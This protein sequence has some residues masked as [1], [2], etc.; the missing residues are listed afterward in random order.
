MPIRDF[1][2]LV[3]D[4][5]EKT[6]LNRVRECLV[7]LQDF[8]RLLDPR[9]PPGAE[10]VDRYIPQMLDRCRRCKGKVLV[11]EIDGRVAGYASILTRVRSEELEDGD[12]EYG[13]VSDLVVVQEFRKLGIGR[14]LLDAAES[15][16]RD[17]G[18]KSLRIGVLDDNEAAKR[19][20]LSM[21]FSGLYVELE[22]TLGGP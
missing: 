5:D 10:I 8:E 7:E 3:R 16:A 2:I 15:H 11:A 4:F 14:K 1:R 19:L 6:H 12:F 17:C 9:M 22:K 13:L 20:Y 21:G 18:V